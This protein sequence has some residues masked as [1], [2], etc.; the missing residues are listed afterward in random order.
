MLAT[1]YRI[2]RPLLFRLDPETAHDLVIALTASTPGLLLR[3]LGAGRPTGPAVR[4]AGL[5]LPSP[6]GLAAGLDKDA[7]AV[8]AWQHLGFGF[9]E[10]G[11]VTPRPQPGNPR[12][13]VHRLPGSQALVHSMGF[14]SDGADVVAG[15]LERLRSRDLWPLTPVGVNLGKNKDTPAE[16]AHVD[17]RTLARRFRDLADFLVVNVSSPNTPGLRELQ[18]PEAL[19]RIAGT[20]VEEAA[21]RPVF[22]KLS[23][24]LADEALAQAVETAL[25][26]GVAGFVA[27][28]TTRTRPVPSD[29][30][31]GLSGVPLHPL[32]RARIQVVLDAVGGRAPVVGVGGID[33]AERAQDLLDRGCAAVQVYTGLI[34]RGPGLAARIARGLSLPAAS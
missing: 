18:A 27:T 21:D 16:T 19:A 11:T 9:V 6:V 4:L 25:G 8:S 5:A 33:R 34:Y 26:V 23:P 13:R 28:N 24:D 10:V 2:A 31:G 14:P 15:R 3:L 1:L 7:R 32:A 29:R 12:P 22:V 17:Y 20:T 30:A